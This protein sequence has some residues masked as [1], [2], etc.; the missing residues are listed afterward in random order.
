MKS[1]TRHGAFAV[2]QESIFHAM[3]S[4]LCNHR[5]FTYPALVG[6]KGQIYKVTQP[7]VKHNCLSGGKKIT[8]QKERAI[9]T[10]GTNDCV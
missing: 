9:S 5:L 1:K 4:A 7:A 8:G 2:R 3:Y 6:N 10:K